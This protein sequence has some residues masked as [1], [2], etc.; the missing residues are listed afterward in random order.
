[1]DKNSFLQYKR[2][3]LTYESFLVTNPFSPSHVDIE[4]TRFIVEFVS[5]LVIELIDSQFMA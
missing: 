4:Q 5:E 2:N 3:K 1:M